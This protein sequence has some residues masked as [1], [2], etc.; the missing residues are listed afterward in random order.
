MASVTSLKVI[1]LAANAGWIQWIQVTS[2][3]VREN[4]LI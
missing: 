4:E 1:V 2:V 3:I